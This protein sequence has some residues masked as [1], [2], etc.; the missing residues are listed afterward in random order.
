MPV[1]CLVQ[2]EC[3]ARCYLLGTTTCSTWHQVV[4][5]ERRDRPRPL[6]SQSLCASVGETNRSDSVTTRQLMRNQAAHPTNAAGGKQ[7]GQSAGMEGPRFSKPP[8]FNR[9]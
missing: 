8:A 9:S 3:S 1:Q 4:E 2:S 5:G 7:G 6:S